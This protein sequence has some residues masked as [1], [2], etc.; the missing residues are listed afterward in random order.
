M[1]RQIEGLVIWRQPPL[2]WNVNSGAVSVEH[3]RNELG[4]DAVANLNTNAVIHKV[5]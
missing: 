1:Q 2:S 3:F 5:N 4:K